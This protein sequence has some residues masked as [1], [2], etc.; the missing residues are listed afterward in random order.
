MHSMTAFA[1]ACALGEADVIV[2]G[3]GPGV[4]GTGTSLGA[5]AIEVASVVD[6]AAA[7]GGRLLPPGI[8]ALRQLA[9]AGR[10]R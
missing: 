3:P 4:V 9:V 8:E 7:L 6:V 10:K 2:V 1:V 5:S